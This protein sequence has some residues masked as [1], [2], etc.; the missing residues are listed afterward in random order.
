MARIQILELPTQVVGEV[1][2]TPFAIIIDQVETETLT[3]STDV[4]F[5]TMSELTQTEADTIGRNLGA[6][7]VVLAAC[8]LDIVR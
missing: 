8:T 2:N 5:R 4:S 1:V 7:G 3:T 6:V